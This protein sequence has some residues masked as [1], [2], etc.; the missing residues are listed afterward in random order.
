MDYMLAFHGET[1]IW[2]AQDEEARAGLETFAA[3]ER[4]IAEVA[5]MFGAETLYSDAPAALA[6]SSLAR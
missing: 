4:E 1:S 5:G 2:R 6:C 3:F